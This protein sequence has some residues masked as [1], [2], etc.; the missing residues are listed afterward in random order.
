MTISAPVSLSGALTLTNNN[1]TPLN[2]SGGLNGN[3]TVTASNML[4]IAGSQAT[5]ISGPGFTGCNGL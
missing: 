2:L 5:T 3:A 1:S 4:T